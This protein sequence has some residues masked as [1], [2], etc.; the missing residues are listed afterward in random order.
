M[1]RKKH[2]ESKGFGLDG[3]TLLSPSAEGSAE[4]VCSTGQ[5]KVSRWSLSHDMHM[6][7]L[8][9][10]QAQHQPRLPRL[11]SL[12]GP[13]LHQ[14]VYL[15][16]WQK[17]APGAHGTSHHEHGPGAQSKSGSGVVSPKCG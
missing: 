13:T 4:E 1:R 5:D 14:N 15:R 8:G 11:C 2:L 10:K 12:F 7:A 17:Q 16:R 9:P 3:A 6:L